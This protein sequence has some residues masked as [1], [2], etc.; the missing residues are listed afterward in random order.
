MT[1]HVN[2]F[3]K[4]Q[5]KFLLFLKL[6]YRPTQWVTIVEAM[7]ITHYIAWALECLIN[8]FL[9]IRTCPFER[10]M[11]WQRNYASELVE[12]TRIFAGL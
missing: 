5:H 7:A 8:E 12:K 10:N 1:I 9:H 11:R 4:N 3:S 6:Q 2:Q